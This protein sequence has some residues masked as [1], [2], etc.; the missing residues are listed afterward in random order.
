MQSP[1]EY[2]FARVLMKPNQ[3]P[4]DTLILDVGERDGVRLGDQVFAHGVWCILEKYLKWMR[5]L[6]KH[7]LYSAPGEKTLARLPASGIDVEL[8]GRGG[9]A[10]SVALSRDVLVAAG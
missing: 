9:G 1:H 4:Y 6:R 2:V 10:F 5:V 8:I 7:C 3:S